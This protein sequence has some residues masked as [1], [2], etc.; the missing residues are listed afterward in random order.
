MIRQKRAT[1]TVL[2][3]GPVHLSA[4]VLMPAPRDEQEHLMPAP[5][6]AANVLPPMLAPHGESMERLMLAPHGESMERLMLAP[7]GESMER[8]MLAP[9]GESMGHLML[10]PHDTDMELLMPAPRD[11]PNQKLHPDKRHPH[12][13]PPSPQVLERIGPLENGVWGHS[14]APNIGAATT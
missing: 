13:R 11:G 9:H 14:W 12:G 6:G 8:L 1:C 7:H 10:A 3:R 4:I 5:L 2:L